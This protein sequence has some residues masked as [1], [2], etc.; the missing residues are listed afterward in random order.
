MTA[1]LV[2]RYNDNEVENFCHRTLAAYQEKRQR[3]EG[4]DA[5]DAV[6][7][8]RLYADYCD[9]KQILQTLGYIQ[10]DRLSG[11]GESLR[12]V[13]VKELLVSELL[14]TDLLPNL[15]PHHLA[16]LASALVYSGRSADGFPLRAQPWVAEVGM[17]VE[18]LHRQVGVQYHLFA[19]VAELVTRWAC[20]HDLLDVLQGMPLQAGDL[21]TLCRQ[22]IDLLRQM[23]LARK[24]DAR[25]LEVLQRATAAVDRDVVQ[26]HL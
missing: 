5:G 8:Q 21:V 25:L 14:H 15:A 13:Y 19:P 7:A 3:R 20:G 18:R 6:A 1:N 16:G 4:Q 23:S 2:A 12:C 9:K 24:D 11:K 26:V 22:V 17:I 10:D